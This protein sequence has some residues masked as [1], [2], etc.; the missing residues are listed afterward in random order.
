MFILLVSISLGGSVL[1]EH[2]YSIS[3]SQNSNIPKKI[4]H[5]SLASIAPEMTQIGERMSRLYHK[6][7]ECCVAHIMIE[8]FIEVVYDFEKLQN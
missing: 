4:K 7:V 5:M 8:L 2:I 1:R 3:G 6:H